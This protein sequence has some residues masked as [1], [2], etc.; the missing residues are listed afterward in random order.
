MQLIAGR[1]DW[2]ERIRMLSQPKFDPNS[3]PGPKIHYPKIRKALRFSDDKQQ[4]KIVVSRPKTR[5]DMTLHT[6]LIQM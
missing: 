2:T 3:K 4:D 1:M 5:R 6:E